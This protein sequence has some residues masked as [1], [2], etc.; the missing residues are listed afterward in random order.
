MCKKCGKK[1]GGKCQASSGAEIA[2]LENTVSELL[3]KVSVI[4]KNAK[5][6][7]CGHPMM[8]IQEA[9]DVASFDVGSGLGADCWEGWAI[10]DGQTQEKPSGGNLV[11]PNLTDRFIVQ[12]GGQY[13]VGDTGGLDDVTLAINEIPTHNHGVTDPGHGHAVTDPG[14]SHGVTDAGHTHTI[15]TDDPGDH[16]HDI[17]NAPNIIGGLGGSGSRAASDP[18]TFGGSG[19]AGAHTHTGTAAN[20]AT[21]VTVNSNATGLTVDSNSTGITTDNAGNG[22]AHENRPPYYAALIVIKL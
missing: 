7:T 19:L 5:F 3:D 12:A 18:V 2:S 4:E 11:T 22:E 8:M 15:S 13:A 6:L 14:H 17:L 1:C 16:Q 9:E 20:S 21:G 10:C